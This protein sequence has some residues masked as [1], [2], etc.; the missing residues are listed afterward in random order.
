MQMLVKLIFDL[1][2]TLVPT[3][4]L[5]LLYQKKKKFDHLVQL[6]FVLLCLTCFTFKSIKLNDQSF[7]L[8]LLFSNLL[9][10]YY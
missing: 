6:T 4:K 8:L 1:T 9:A 7:I 5:R 3:L 2:Y 10:K